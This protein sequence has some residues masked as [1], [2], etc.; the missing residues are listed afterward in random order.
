MIVKCLSHKKIPSIPIWYCVVYV[1]VFLPIES[2]RSIHQLRPDDVLSLTDMLLFHYLYQDLIAC[3]LQ[4]LPV[5]SHV[6]NYQTF[7]KVR[8][9]FSVFFSILSFSFI[10]SNYLPST[11]PAYN[12]CHVMLVQ[13]SHRLILLPSLMEKAVGSLLTF[14]VSNVVYVVTFLVFQIFFTILHKISSNTPFIPFIAC[15]HSFIAP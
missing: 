8:A 10:L 2:L 6:H 9:L 3:K 14:G 5:I 4:D 7:C 12:S 15:F 11:T 13:L 1:E